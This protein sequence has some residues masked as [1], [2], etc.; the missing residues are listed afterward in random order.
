MTPS[1]LELAADIDNPLD[2]VPPGRL[3]FWVSR[4]LAETGR[5]TVARSVVCDEVWARRVELS[6]RIGPALQAYRQEEADAAVARSVCE[7]AYLL[8][9][10]IAG[11]GFVALLATGAAAGTSL[12]KHAHFPVG[13]W[14]I[15]AAAVLLL[16]TAVI[17]KG[18]AW[19]R[20][21]RIRDRQAKTYRR[22]IQGEVLEEITVMAREIIRREEE[23]VYGA[24]LH[25]MQTPS[26]VELGSPAVVRSERFR[27]VLALISGHATSAIGVSGPRGAGKSTLLRLLCER[28]PGWVGVY[29]PIPASASEAQLIKMIYGA[30]V[31]EV[32]LSRYVQL[33]KR[34][35]TPR[36]YGRDI[37]W[38]SQKLDEITWSTSRQWVRKAGLARWGLSAETS[39]QLTRT[40]REVGPADWVADFRG[41]IQGHRVRNG[42]SI[43]VAIDE[44]DKI[45]DPERAID[46]INGIKDLFHIE[47]LHFVVSVSDDALRGFALRGIPM[48][49][50]FDSAFDTVIDVGTLRAEESF[51]LL[52]RRAPRFPYP[53]ALFC[54][55]WS[56]GLPRELI[57]T[58]R[59]CVAIQN[60]R[61]AP[62][63]VAELAQTIVR[64]HVM[65]V[66][67]AA[68][69]RWSG[70]GSRSQI[71][72][73]LELRRL[74]E[75]V[76]VPPHPQLA[77]WMMPD[78]DDDGDLRYASLEAFIHVAGAISEY[79]SAP[80]DSEHWAR[81][82]KSGEFLLHTDRLA[83]AKAALAMHPSEAIWKLAHARDR[84][85][86]STAG[87]SGTEQSTS[88][89]SA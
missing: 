64:R 16:V 55:A 70:D 58:A 89:S 12:V 47:G 15:G 77:G 66:I 37:V 27:E 25:Q 26:L 87:S 60:R 11:A 76:E 65:E 63:T 17:L 10:C 36:K 3:V 74:L 82:I 75:G 1:F 85:G 19:D 7:L 67:D 62:V 5:T 42:A 56:G 69:R 8:G 49:D 35:R 84:I 30:I 23:R 51:E 52:Q 28:T 48:R 54:H 22:L 33:S 31:R 24:L 14:L 29:L 4:A 38:A 68:I 83:E 71:D 81:G 50:A 46:V 88:G 2:P 80:R 39:G 72:A 53:A 79:F 34:G 13:L 18:E 73:L 40:E 6:D 61:N 41:Y 21:D 78:A 86:L 20:Q 32:L 44:L 45:A 43:V 59:S 9:S 57:R